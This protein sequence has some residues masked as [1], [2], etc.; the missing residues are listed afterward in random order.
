M[1]TERYPQAFSGLNQYALLLSTLGIERGLIGPREVP[2]LW[3]RHILNCAVVAEPADGL[4]PPDAT[5]VDI[6]TGAGLPGVVW[7]L[8]RPDISV[9][10]VDSMLRRVEFLELAVNEL[11]L[12]DRVSVV[13]GR[14]EDLAGSLVGDVVTARAV[15][16]LPKLLTWLGPFVSDGGSILAFKGQTAGV[17]ILEAGHPI[18]LI[19]DIQG[20]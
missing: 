4:I 5:V 14:A 19:Q 17:E 9:T 10:L 13:R 2:R 8:T 16:P 6:G 18:N 3:D 15:A 20:N 7:A 11:E 12:T 1:A